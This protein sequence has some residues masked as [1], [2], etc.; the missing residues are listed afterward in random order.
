MNKK[1]EKNHFASFSN[2]NWT[3]ED[4]LLEVKNFVS[5]QTGI[6]ISNLNR[7][8]SLSEDL[9][10]EGDDANDFMQAFSKTFDVELTNF[11]FDKYFYPEGAFN[12]ISYLIYRK[13]FRRPKLQHIPI[14]LSRLVEAVLKRK[15]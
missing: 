14:T 10:I 2:S 5:Q 8:S 11:V 3:N 12:P 1:T 15:W 9:G 4:G 7:N 6:S 13:L